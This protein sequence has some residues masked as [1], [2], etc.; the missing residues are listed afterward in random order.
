MANARPL[1]ARSG[2]GQ[3]RA[4][5]GRAG[6]GRAGQGRG[7]SIVIVEKL[8][9]SRRCRTACACPSVD[10]PTYRHVGEQAMTAGSGGFRCGGSAMRRG[11]EQ[12]GAWHPWVRGRTARSGWTRARLRSGARA[13]ADGE[14]TLPRPSVGET[15]RRAARSGIRREER[16]SGKNDRA[17]AFPSLRVSTRRRGC[18]CRRAPTRG[19]PIVASRPCPGGGDAEQGG[20]T[21]CSAS[22]ALR[23]AA[24][25]AVRASPSAMR[26]PA[27][28]TRRAHPG[29]MTRGRVGVSTRQQQRGGEPLPRHSSARY[30]RSA[31]AAL[32][33]AAAQA[34][35]ASPSA[36]R[37][38]V[39][40]ARHVHPGNMTHRRVGVSTRQQ[41]RGGEPLPRHSGARYGRSATPASPSA[42]AQAKSASPS[43][44][45]RPPPVA[46]HAHPDNMTHRRVGMSTRQQQR[47]GE[48]LPTP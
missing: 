7:Q 30:G 21:P 23:P 34:E 39:P 29:D 17:A 3:G 31:T 43:A 2:A 25:R 24:V 5:Q 40:V 9:R 37:R 36:L 14:G 26:R 11:E 19:T 28:V 41:Q 45:R 12:S 35:S 10:M 1:A 16:C 20:V 32:P 27:P 42:A 44:M 8:A 48:P 15:G 18:R 46:R 13:Y 47:G 38:P 22:P 6:Q 33:I 4:G